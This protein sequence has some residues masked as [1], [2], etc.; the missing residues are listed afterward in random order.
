MIQPISVFFKENL[1]HAGVFTVTPEKQQACVCTHTRTYPWMSKCPPVLEHF[2]QAFDFQSFVFTI[3][4]A[5]PNLS[6]HTIFGQV[7]RGQ[8]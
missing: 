3:D 2:E 7:I 6:P 4:G 1:G 8:E 5:F